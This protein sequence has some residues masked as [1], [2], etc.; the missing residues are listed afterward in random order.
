MTA[1]EIFV[2]KEAMDAASLYLVGKKLAVL[3]EQAM[4]TPEGLPAEPTTERLVLRALA[5]RLVLRAVAERPGLTVGE[6]A[7]QLSIAQ[8]RIS[9]VVAVLEREGFVRRYTD[10]H[11]RRRQRIEAT[12]QYKRM[13]EQRMMRQAEEALGPLLTH[14]TAR[15]KARVFAALDLI[16]E[17]ILR[18]EGREDVGG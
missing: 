9:Q 4:A 1:F 12:A 8:S 7:R 11:D 10:A 15:E 6:L 5:E 14:A 16:H 13:V 2:T 17:L 18:T 3:A